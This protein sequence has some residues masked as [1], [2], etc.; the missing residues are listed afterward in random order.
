MQ[1]FFK[2][3]IVG[4]LILVW[5][6]SIGSAESRSFYAGFNGTADAVSSAGNSKPAPVST[7]FT[8]ADGISGKSIV[9]GPASLSYAAKG[10]IDPV[11]GSISLWMQPQNWDSNTKGLIPIF[12]LG[13]SHGYYIHYYLYYNFT[14]S[15][16]KM[17]TFRSRLDANS[18]AENVIQEEV[19]RVLKNSETVFSKNDW[20]HIVCTWT[21]W[22]LFIYVNGQLFGRLPYSMPVQVPPLKEDERIWIADNTFWDINGD[23]VTKVD[24]LEIFN[25]AL[26][27][28]EVKV[29]YSSRKSSLKAQVVPGTIPVPKSPAKPTIDGKLDKTEWADATRVPV[30]KLFAHSSFASIPA[31]CY[32]KYDQQSLYVAFEVKHNSPL[33]LTGK[34]RDLELFSGDEAEITLRTPN[35]QGYYQFAVAP[36]GAYAY[37]NG[38]EYPEARDWKWKGSFKSAV[39]REAGVWYAEMVI[40]FADLLATP[41]ADKPW[42]VQLGLHRAVEDSLGGVSERWVAYG[43]GEDMY[44]RPSSMASLYF[45]PDGTAVRVED[46]GDINAGRLNASVS[47]RGADLTASINI[48][49]PETKPAL[50]DVALKA[51]PTVLKIN[52]SVLGEGLLRLSVT[53]KDKADPVFMYNALYYAKA[54]L[55]ISSVCH[56]KAGVLD[57]IT[58]MS[59]ASDLIQRKIKSGK[60]TGTATLVSIKDGKVFGKLVFDQTKLQATVHMKFKDLPVGK[61]DIRVSLTDKQDT[62]KANIS[63]EKP[64]AVF[65][66]AKAGVDRT[67]PAPWSPVKASGNTVSVW[68]RDYVFGDGPFVAKA[69][70]NG[71]SVINRPAE[72]N[73]TIAGKV[74]RFVAVNEKLADN[75]QDKVIHT[76][77]CELSGGGLTMLWQRTVE[78][79]GMIRYDVSL[80]PGKSPVKLDALEF[81]MRV[82][83]EAA[84]F[85]LSPQYLSDW[86]KTKK[87]S[88]APGDSIWF[89]GRNSGMEFF[90]VSDANWV[91]KENSKPISVY[92]DGDDAVIKC[93]IISGPVNVTK[94]LSYTLGMMA[95]PF[96]PERPDRRSIH[97]EG[98]GRPTRQNLQC[99]TQYAQSQRIQWPNGVIL[100]DMLNE[101]SGLEELAWW[102]SRG[103]GVSPY[104]LDGN[105][106]DNNPFYDYFGVD[107]ALFNNGREAPKSFRMSQPWL[108]QNGQ[109][110]Y[111]CSSACVNSTYADFLTWCTQH[112]LTK[113]PFI[114]T[115]NDGGGGSSSPCDS[116]SHGCKVIDAFG[117]E[118]KTY[119]Y[120]AAREINKRL[121]KIVRKLRPNGFHWVH[122]GALGMPFMTSLCDIQYMGEDYLNS[123]PANAR[124][125]TDEEDALM[126]WQSQHNGSLKGTAY[127]FSGLSRPKP[128]DNTYPP[129]NPDLWRPLFTMALLHDVMLDGAWMY[130]PTIDKIWRIVDVTELDK[131]EFVGYWENKEITSDN[132]KVLVSYYKWPGQGKLLVIAGNPSPEPQSARIQFKGSLNV[133]MTDATDMW[134]DKPIDMSGGISLV[135]R[136]FRAILL[137]W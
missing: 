75:G 117:R 71:K 125:Y 19:N 116:P 44:Q 46:M 61:Y 82:P 36:N 47:G 131:A 130:G 88:A 23:F 133:P 16:E 74:R 70:S 5:C 99:Y 11:Q 136:D 79:D 17:L 33:K 31:W 40:P 10:N 28:D 45:Y 8:F 30:N 76:G 87:H 134:L 106:A 38:G 59:G 15:G 83:M 92:Q 98:W 37:S 102:K 52:D 55:V 77:K 67:V 97:A 86:A 124:I 100:T 29:M 110:F 2:T 9:L 89:A 3:A 95:T 66:T 32:L 60:M 107:W 129:A 57:I 113:Y 111:M 69:T 94:K 62:L 105:T 80:V 20:T 63:F 41:E 48:L 96:R 101:K 84:M 73:A 49:H 4:L 24:E 85:L 54:P 132:P 103:V 93:R 53:K 118:A 91:Y 50:S 22:E 35:E 78:F 109:D 64:N 104:T 68:G 12:W 90:T 27:A 26:T 58:D 56:A 127:I 51:K 112:Y 114:G 14:A 43:G 121:Y 42:L 137:K 115:Y 1:L 25:K 123:A 126:K 72:M 120:L 21:T 81:E 34:G 128:E 6:A 119:N 18:N 135:D 39:S 7:D 65:L 108:T 13:S 122:N